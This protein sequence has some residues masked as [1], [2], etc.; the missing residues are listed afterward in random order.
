MRNA[1]MYTLRCVCVCVYCLMQDDWSFIF[2]VPLRALSVCIAAA[3]WTLATKRCSWEE[4]WR[5]G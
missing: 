5:E 4:S 3:K 2:S 1:S